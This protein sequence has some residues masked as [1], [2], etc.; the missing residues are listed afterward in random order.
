MSNIQTVQSFKTS[1]GE[2]FGTLVAAEAHESF[3]ENKEAIDA[4]VVSF[5]NA[6]GAVG[7]SRAIQTASATK[8]L[9]WYLGWD[10]EEVA[11]TVFEAPAA[12]V[13]AEDGEEVASKAP[14]AKVKAV[15]AELE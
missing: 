5:V 13:V 14:K 7:R 2:I 10:G 1:D 3:L 11:Q 8:F 9:S 6:T 4:A 12:E 15:A